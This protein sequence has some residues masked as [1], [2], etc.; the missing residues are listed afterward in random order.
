MEARFF[1]VNTNGELTFLHTEANTISLQ[2]FLRYN[3]IGRVEY[4]TDIKNDLIPLILPENDIII[5]QNNQS[6]WIHSKTDILNIQSDFMLNGETLNCMLNWRAVKPFE[7]TDTVENIIRSLITDKFMTAGNNYISNFKLANTIGGTSVTTYNL[8]EEK[9]KSLLEVVRELCKIDDLGFSVDVI[10]EEL[11]F[12]LYR[13]L[14]RT[15]DQ[16]D[17]PAVTLS[18]DEKTLYESEYYNSQMDYYSHGIYPSDLETWTDI[19]KD[20]VTGFRRREKVLYSSTETEAIEELSE[21]KK[22]EEIRGKAEIQYGKDYNLGDILTIQRKIGEALI[23]KN[24]RVTG[25]DIV[26]EN[27]YVNET[28]ILEEAL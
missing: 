26:Y 23:V 5:V 3:D 10:N 20:N 27:S 15:Q 1:S 2:W 22:R 25:V 17:R 16:T 8:L 4:H 13:G 19:Q 11:V 24:E 9:S 12:K 14:D 21:F 7:M 28:P 18:E 6:A